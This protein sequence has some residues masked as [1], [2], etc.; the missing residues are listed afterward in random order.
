MPFATGKINTN[1]V[2]VISM[3]DS[4]QSYFSVVADI[5]SILN[6]VVRG[7]FYKSQ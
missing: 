1:D 6:D 4:D 2:I 3:N 5:V 7:E